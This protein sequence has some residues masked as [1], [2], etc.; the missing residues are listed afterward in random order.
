MDPSRGE[1]KRHLQRR[2]NM[3]IC[4]SH[5]VA[6]RR[7]AATREASRISERIAKRIADVLIP[8]IV[9]EIDAGVMAISQERIPQRTVGEI[10][11]GAASR[12]QEQIVQVANVIPQ[13][14][15]SPAQQLSAAHA[16]GLVDPQFSVT[17]VE[18]SVPQVV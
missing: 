15:L 6:E 16:T 18:T 2:P 3:C 14:R 4:I 9:K 5:L 7:G 17:A 10:T 13:E 1:L 8:V 12:L 11:N